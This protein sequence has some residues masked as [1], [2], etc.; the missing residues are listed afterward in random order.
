MNNKRKK[1]FKDNDQKKKNHKK[2]PDKM[3]K[4]KISL[5]ELEEKLKEEKDDKIIEFLMDKKVE[6]TEVLKFDEIVN[7]ISLLANEF[8]QKTF[9]LNKEGKEFKEINREYTEKML[10]LLNRDDFQTDII[11]NFKQRLLDN[12]LVSN[13]FTF[14]KKIRDDFNICYRSYRLPDHW[15]NVRDIFREVKDEKKLMTKYENVK[16]N[17]CKKYITI[18]D[19]L[20]LENVSDED[21]CKLIESYSMMYYYKKEEALPS[22]IISRNKLESEY[23]M[24]KDKKYTLELVNQRELLKS[25]NDDS[26]LE[27]Y[28]FKL[29]LDII[30]KKVIYSYYT[31]MV[32]LPKNDSDRYKILEWIQTI[33]SLP[34]NKNINNLQL[35]DSRYNILRNIKEKLDEKIYGLNIV[36]EEIL[37][38]INS[39]LSNPNSNDNSF[40]LCSAAGMGKT[41]IIRLL[42]E[43]MIYPFYQISMGGMSEVSMLE[44]HS[45]TYTGSKPG[46]IVIALKNMGTN[47]GILYFDE[48][49]KIGQTKSGEEVSNSLLHITDFTQNNK[50]YDKYIG[51][52]PMDLSK[53]WFIFSCNNLEKIDPI[54][55]NRIKRKIILPEYN[56]KDKIEIIKKLLPNICENIK[57]NVND[58]II[59]DEIFEY[60]LNNTKE[61]KGLRT[62]IATTETILK[63]IKLL[64]DV[65]DQ[66]NN[67]K[68]SFHIKIEKLPLI[69]T[70]KNMEILMKNLNKP[71]EKFSFMYL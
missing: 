47:N 42:S 12:G 38:I 20:E 2:E 17:L 46:S 1:S 60:I 41:R 70:I 18:Q 29:D 53:L 23:K 21:M 22:F 68:I 34:F 65:N 63:K 7:K 62:L 33:I 52:I 9:S 67:L 26:M 61:E 36:K 45:Y 3:D 15:T 44:G 59:S 39:K 37:M 27:E 48:I 66:N 57:L 11:L 51:E 50:Y 32:S 5:I 30:Y 10:I 19:I 40:C 6:M 43:I 24:I 25:V 56:K 4:I 54:L 71:E 35:N 31:K 58:I 8:D 64:L 14:N 28:I 16:T 55:S 13:K 49:D 69:L